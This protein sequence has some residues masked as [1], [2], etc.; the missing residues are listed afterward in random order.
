[1]TDQRQNG[2][3]NLQIQD[4]DITQKNLQILDYDLHEPECQVGVDPYNS[5]LADAHAPWPKCPV[6]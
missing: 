5:V 4:L 1:M 2:A 3:V 6:R